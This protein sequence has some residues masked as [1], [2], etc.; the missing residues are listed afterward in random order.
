MLYYSPYLLHSM[1]VCG[2][3]LILPIEI[4]Q[5]GF[6]HI[7]EK[8]NVSAYLSLK[9]DTISSNHIPV[10]EKKRVSAGVAQNVRLIFQFRRMVDKIHIVS[11]H[12]IFHDIAF[13][14]RRKDLLVFF[15]LE[16]VSKLEV[17]YMM[18]LMK[19]MPTI[20]KYVTF[21]AKILENLV[22]KVEHILLSLWR[23]IANRWHFFSRSFKTFKLILSPFFP[24]NQ[25]FGQTAQR[26]REE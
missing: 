21:V 3:F 8:R 13:P 7:D 9:N 17:K 4:N 11:L 10:W 16:K 1:R 15:F 2:Q 6:W 25:Y 22:S 12:L 24:M 18:V 26:E 14:C 20:K 5:F 23:H 19:G